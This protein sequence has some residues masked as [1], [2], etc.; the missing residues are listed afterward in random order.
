MRGAVGA[1]GEITPATRLGDAARIVLSV[2]RAL[3]LVPFAHVLVLLLRCERLNIKAE[4]N[5][6]T[7]RGHELG[8]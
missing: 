1:G 4:A 8:F 2:L 5:L 7:E 6:Y 3:N